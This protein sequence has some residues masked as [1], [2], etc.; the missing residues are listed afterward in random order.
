M[1]ITIGVLA[2]KGTDKIDTKPF[3]QAHET[4]LVIAHRGGS[5]YPEN[6]IPA[7]LHSVEIG[8]DMIEFDVHM[9]KD[10]HLVV[11]HDFTVDRTTNGQGRVDSFT[12]AE[13]QQLDAGYHHTSSGGT[14]PY[15]NQGITIPTVREVFERLPTTFMNIELKGQYPGIEQRL[16][17]LIEEFQMQDRILLA[18]FEQSVIEKFNEIAQGTVAISGG[19]S[20][21]AKFVALHKL[22]LAPFYR[23]KVDAIQ[24]PTKVSIF[25]MGD[26]KLIKGA[27]KRGMQVHYW[28]I[29]DREQMKELLL[30][31]ADGII[32]DE[33]ELLLEVI[34]E[35]GLRKSK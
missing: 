32:T 30:L 26:K 13:L 22:F 27:H 18:S 17:E 5:T 11:I 34:R 33:P 29:N 10:G 35:L 1:T 24:F 16:F 7:L 2:Q 14:F 19:R 4:P 3:F 6:T 15:R 21:V 23:P 20:E 8:A 28:T 9:T 25:N 31:G 12:L